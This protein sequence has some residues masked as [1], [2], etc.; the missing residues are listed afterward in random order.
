[1]KNLTKLL[2]VVGIL[3]SLLSCG[4]EPVDYTAFKEANK[5]EINFNTTDKMASITYVAA[6]GS[7]EV[8]FVLAKTTDANGYLFTALFDPAALSGVGSTFNSVTIG[9]SFADVTVEPIGIKGAKELE[10]ADIKDNKYGDAFD[11]NAYVNA[12]YNFSKVTSMHFPYTDQLFGSNLF[13]VDIEVPELFD[14]I[15]QTFEELHESLK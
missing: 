4:G 11:I 3:F 1:M 2:F 12:K 9:K 7:L 5:V 8:V 14:I 6:D 10:F 13:F 15:Q